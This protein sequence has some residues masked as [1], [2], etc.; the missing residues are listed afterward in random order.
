MIKENISPNTNTT[1]KETLENVNANATNNK[2]SPKPNVLE[3][4]V[5]NF[6]FEYANTMNIKKTTKHR[7][8]IREVLNNSGNALLYNNIPEQIA[9]IGNKNQY[10]NRSFIS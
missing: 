3:M 6:N 1:K 5:L 2:L 10:T 7:L 9:M 4:D 8:I